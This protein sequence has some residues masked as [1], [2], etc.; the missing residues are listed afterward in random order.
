M[1][2]LIKTDAGVMGSDAKVRAYRTHDEA[3]EVMKREFTEWYVERYDLLSA[4]NIGRRWD[5][6]DDDDYDNGA[7]VDEGEFNLSGNEAYDGYGDDSAT[8]HVFEVRE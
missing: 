8:W 1:F 6:V 3:Y 4:D 5:E 2:V 7:R